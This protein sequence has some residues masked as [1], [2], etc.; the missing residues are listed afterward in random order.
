MLQ[1]IAKRPVKFD[2]VASGLILY[3][4]IPNKNSRALVLHKLASKYDTSLRNHLKEAYSINESTE[5]QP[6][7]QEI[8]GQRTW[9]S[10]IKHV[11]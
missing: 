8:E 2:S 7:L 3:T 6:L 10:M 11:Y 5:A 9:T 1:G 4:K